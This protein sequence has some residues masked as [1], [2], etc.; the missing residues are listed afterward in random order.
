MLMKEFF[1][2]GL[3]YLPIYLTGAVIADLYFP[4]HR[5][6]VGWVALSIAQF[7]YAIVEAVRKTA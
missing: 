1:I 4:D 5:F 3:V 6:F 7:A 2:T